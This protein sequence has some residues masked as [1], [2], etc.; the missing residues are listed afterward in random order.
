MLFRST[1]EQVKLIGRYTQNITLVY[2]ADKAGLRATRTNCEQFLRAGFTVK[3]IELPD[4][5]DPDDIAREKGSDSRA[6]LSN[7][8]TDFTSY[9]A[10][11]FFGKY[12]D[13]TPDQIEAE[14][15]S[16]CSLIACISSETL[17]LNHIRKVSELFALNTEIIGRKLKEQIDRK[18][19]V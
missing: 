11:V 10:N 12:P 18:S 15:N 4:G 17:R 16:I 8:E 1:P 7:R 14:L 9:F 19:V 2:D 6:W 3:C 13:P 5:Q